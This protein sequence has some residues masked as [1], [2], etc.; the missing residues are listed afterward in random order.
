MNQE[1]EE[2]NNSNEKIEV[3]AKEDS[4]NVVEKNKKAKKRRRITVLIISIIAILFA[5]IEAR[6][7]YLE[8]KE[9]GSF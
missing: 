6:G 7:N 3:N 4:I 1:N 2:T 9:I 5:Y 8:I